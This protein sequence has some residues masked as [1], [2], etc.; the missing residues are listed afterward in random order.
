MRDNLSFYEHESEGKSVAIVGIPM[1][2]GSDERGLAKAPHYLLERGLEKVIA[3]LGADVTNVTMVPCRTPERTVST[4]S[5]K[6]L[7]EI[8]AAARVSRAVVERA[9][10]RGDI[11]IALGGDHSISIGTIAG[12]ST[13]NPNKRLGVIWIDAHPDVNTD[14]TSVSGNVHG[15]PTAALMGFGHPFL[16]GVGGNA[17]KVRPEDFLYLGLKDMDAAEI[18]FLRREPV[19]AVTMFDIEERGLSR[20]VFA[21]D[22]LCRKVDTVWV[23]MDMDSID[24]EYAPGVGMPTSGGFTRREILNLAQY[25]GK[26]C[27]LAG[28]DIVEIV[29]AKDKGG[30]T[31]VL[32]LELIARFLGGDYSWYESYMQEYRN[33]NV[34]NERELKLVKAYGNRKTARS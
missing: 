15:M 13:A 28:L 21:I 11:V 1:E 25:I 33:T 27:N 31:A 30:K 20:A 23:S 8:T 18:E 12:A 19:R 5:A 29:P 7:E 17:P 3:S 14:E 10:Q 32:A 4:G 26:T 16:M 2:L 22:A 6:Y 24:K 34:T 9:V